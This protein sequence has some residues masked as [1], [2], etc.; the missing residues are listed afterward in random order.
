ML[1]M[2][3]RQCACV[4]VCVCVC[5]YTLRKGTQDSSR[6][7]RH[8]GKSDRQPPASCQQGQ[9]GEQL[10]LV[11]E[12]MRLWEGTGNGE[13]FPP[14]S[15]SQQAAPHLGYQASPPHPGWLPHPRLELSGAQ[16]Q[17]P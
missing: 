1:G 8:A 3:T 14:K 5:Q 10:F 17:N 13:E 16:R 12:A 11:T 15:P 9:G 7:V 4:C 2:E 6:N